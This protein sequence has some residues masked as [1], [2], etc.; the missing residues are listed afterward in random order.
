MVPDSSMSGF[1]EMEEL[2]EWIFVEILALSI[3]FLLVISISW[4]LQKYDSN[5][6]RLEKKYI[7]TTLDDILGG[8]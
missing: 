8:R 7:H 6:A 3:T 2:D 4:R 1:G 5:T